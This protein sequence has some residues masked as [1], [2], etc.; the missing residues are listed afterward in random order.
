MRDLQSPES[1][2]PMKSG[3]NH[4]KTQTKIWT[5]VSLYCHNTERESEENVASGFQ[6]DWKGI[7]STSALESISIREASQTVWIQ[8]ISRKLQGYKLFAHWKG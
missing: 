6:A 5:W 2:F 1:I 7:Y 3:P 4:L 8:R